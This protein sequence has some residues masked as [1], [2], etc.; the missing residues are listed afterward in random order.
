MNS[1][2]GTPAKP[3]K[4]NDH[5]PATQHCAIQAMF[6]VSVRVT[7]QYGLLMFLP[8][9][10]AVYYNGSHT[11]NE[12]ANTDGYECETRLRGCKGIRRTLEDIGESC[13]EEKQHRKCETCVKRDEKDYRL[14]MISSILDEAA[15][16]LANIPLLKACEEVG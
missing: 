5:A 2:V 10:R 11:S 7:F 12:Y 1:F 9:E 13:K 6:R 15:W 16:G 3:E 4:T 8:V 14:C